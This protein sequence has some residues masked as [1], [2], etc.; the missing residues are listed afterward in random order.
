M[1][2]EK[3]IIK[4]SIF[5]V[6]IFTLLINLVYLSYEKIYEGGNYAADNNKII[7]YYEN[8]YLNTPLE[9]KQQIICSNLKS[10]L[11]NIAV[12][13]KLVSLSILMTAISVVV[14]FLMLT[15]KKCKRI[16]LSR[17]DIVIIASIEIISL[18][19]FVWAF[20]LESDYCFTYCVYF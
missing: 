16:I 18:F 6:I 12:Y 14:V 11:G 1:F 20:I 4:L 5:F 3:R 17:K 8:T 10:P 15:L 2:N 19:I 7:S 9:I 13:Y